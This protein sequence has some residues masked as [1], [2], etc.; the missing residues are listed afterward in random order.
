MNADDV[1]SAI[2]VGKQAPGA[3]CLAIRTVLPM[4]EELRKGRAFWIQWGVGKLVAAL[5]DYVKES[6]APAASS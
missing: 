1:R 3:M 5:E 6:C 2:A 4:I